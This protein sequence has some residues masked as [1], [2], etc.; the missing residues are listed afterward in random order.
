LLVGVSAVR[1]AEA[2]PMDSFDIAGEYTA[3]RLI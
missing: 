1:A 3:E 2:V